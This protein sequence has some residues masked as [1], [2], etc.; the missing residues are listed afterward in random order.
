MIGGLRHR[1]ILQRRLDAPDGG[2][3]VI[4]GWSDIAG[5]WAEVTPLAGD[6][7]VQAMGVQDRQKFRVR[8]RYRE[9]ISGADR[10]LF[11]QRVLNI[12]SLINAGERGQWLECR[13]EEGVGG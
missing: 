7:T 2:G 12:R 1:V 4:L 6:E 5:L 3:G 10:L 13:C 9:D 8:L 11:R